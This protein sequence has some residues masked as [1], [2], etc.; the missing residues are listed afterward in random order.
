MYNRRKDC[1]LAPSR[2]TRTNKVLYGLPNKVPYKHQLWPPAARE[3]PMLECHLFYANPTT[4]DSISFVTVSSAT[5]GC[6][7]CNAFSFRRRNRKPS[8]VMESQKLS[9]DF[10]SVLAR[11]LF[12]ATWLMMVRIPISPQLLRLLSAKAL[13]PQWTLRAADGQKSKSPVPLLQW[14]SLRV[15][16]QGIM[17]RQQG[18]GGCW[19]YEMPN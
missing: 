19:K 16:W 12:N 18:G 10:E 15:N 5:L 13:W 7:L 14:E 4:Q 2:L 11:S 9:D 6:A 1:V 8:W 3:L 17:G